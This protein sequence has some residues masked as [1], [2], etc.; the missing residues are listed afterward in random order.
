MKNPCYNCNER[1]CGCHCRCELYIKWKKKTDEINEAIS[2][3]KLVS[4]GTYSLRQHR[5]KRK[6]AMK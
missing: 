5:F 3:N 2:E 4:D 1:A 6:V